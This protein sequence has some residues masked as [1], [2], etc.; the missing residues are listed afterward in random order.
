MSSF[1]STIKICNVHPIAW[2]QQKLMLSELKESPN[3]VE[4]EIH[5]DWDKQ[6]NNMVWFYSF[7]IE[8]HP[9]WEEEVVSVIKKYEQPS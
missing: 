2:Q 7:D 8:N 6:T 1:T 3:Y 9:K 4:T 5:H